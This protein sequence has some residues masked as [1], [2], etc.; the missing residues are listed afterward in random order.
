MLRVVLLFVTCAVVQHLEGANL[1][2]AAYENNKL[3]VDRLCA[4][5]HCPQATVK[6]K[7]EVSLMS[8]RAVF[9]TAVVKS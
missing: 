9:V 8:W 5:H 3:V 6:D 2:G 1:Q 7:A 4:I